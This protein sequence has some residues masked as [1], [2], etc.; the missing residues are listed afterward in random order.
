MA[1]TDLAM[2]HSQAALEY[3]K[4]L[5]SPYITAGANALGVV[6]SR[7]F[8]SSERKA[9]A[10]AQR[11]TLQSK[12]QQLS[13]PTDWTTFPIQVGE[14]A[15]ER[16]EM[17]FKQAEADRVR[18]LE[19][20]Q[21]ELALFDKQQGELAPVFEEQDLKN[22]A[23]L[24]RINASL[25]NVAKLSNIP[26]SLADI[27]GE[28]ENDPV[29]KFRLAEGERAI[30][31][32]AAAKGIFRSGKAVEEIADFSMALT[33][34]ETDKLVNRR[35][36]AL[37]GAIAGLNAELGE[38]SQSVG[39]ALSIAQLGLGGAGTLAG[40]TMG[41]AQQQMAGAA[42]AGQTQ[43]T[44]TLAA[45]KAQADALGGVANTAGS[46]AALTML[47]RPKADA[48][49]SSFPDAYSA[50][51]VRLAQANTYGSITQF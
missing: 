28:L 5:I 4:G 2:Q 24:D 15:S 26:A 44:G 11:S 30:N 27:R 18:N 1:Q 40:A 45:G 20:A 50:E 19:A 7:V 3:I 32:A 17:L 12:I 25:D 48:T 49:I 42:Q 31:R 8:S 13:K 47:S 41:Q 14:K 9:A 43:M 39:Q 21:A 16:R 46:L 38:Q 22:Q 34:E 35:V 36:I 10:T 51:G 6:Q 29:Y 23:R 37:Q 33:G